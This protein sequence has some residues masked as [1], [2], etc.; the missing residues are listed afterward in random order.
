MHRT[1][2]DKVKATKVS[3]AERLA[4][5]QLYTATRQGH[6]DGSCA[7]GGGGGESAAATYGTCRYFRSGALRSALC[8]MTMPMPMHDGL[9]RCARSGY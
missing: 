6:D 3:N 5:G 8:T 9:T 2:T 1:S 4:C 7:A